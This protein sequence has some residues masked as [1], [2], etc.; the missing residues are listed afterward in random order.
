MPQIKKVTLQ[1]GKVRYR[2]VVGMS[3]E[4]EGKRK[5]HIVT[6]DTTKEARDEI[7]RIRN[8]RATGSSSR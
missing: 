2:A 5:Q 1:S 7:A 4:A 6:M 8:Q 3:Y